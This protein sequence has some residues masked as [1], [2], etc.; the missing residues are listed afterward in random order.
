MLGCEIAARLS[1]QL[2]QQFGAAP[3]PGVDPSMPTGLFTEDFMGQLGTQGT[4]GFDPLGNQS[5]GA[6]EVARL[7][8][9]NPAALQML[10]QAV[11]QEAAAGAKAR[12]E[13]LR[14]SLPNEDIEDVFFVLHRPGQPGAGR[15]TT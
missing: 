9:G 1:E 4:D 11:L 2:G 13:L 7:V 3:P 6:G 15:E 12:A 14:M 10:R 5:P 8:Q